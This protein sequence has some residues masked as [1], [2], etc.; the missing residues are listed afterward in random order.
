MYTIK[1]ILPILL[2]MVVMVIGQ[3]C[4]DFLDKDPLTDTN[5]T[6]EEIFSDER[7]APGFL[8]SVINIS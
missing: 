3:S 6:R 2:M 1:N 8:N 5:L 4:S 7:Y